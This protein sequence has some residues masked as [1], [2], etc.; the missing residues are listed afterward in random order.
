MNEGT[1]LFVCENIGMD[2]ES[3]VEIIEKDGSTPE[4]ARADLEKN[5]I[6]TSETMWG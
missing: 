4:E 5:L 1:T 3:D 6:E 2:T